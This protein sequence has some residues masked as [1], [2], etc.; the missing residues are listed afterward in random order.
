M[1][2]MMV[3][4]KAK[5]VPAS[6]TN[7]VFLSAILRM[8]SKVITIIINLIIIIIIRGCSYIGGVRPIYYNWR[9]GG[10]LM[11]KRGVFRI[12]ISDRGQESGETI[13]FSQN[14]HSHCFF[15]EIR[16]LK[17]LSSKGFEFWSYDGI[18][19]DDG[20][21]IMCNGIMMLWW[22]YYGV[23]VKMYDGIMVWSVWRWCQ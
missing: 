4:T 12:E 15:G 20:K 14:L 13:I 10:H 7:K 16:Q 5:A 3:T 19:F 1:I 6:C 11:M 22:W 18:E 2:A 21:N 9:G 8:S 17:Y 23:M